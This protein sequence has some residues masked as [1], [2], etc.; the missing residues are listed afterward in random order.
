MVGLIGSGV[1]FGG[2]ATL[3]FYRV[4][5]SSRPTER[6]FWSYERLGKPLIH[7]TPRGRRLAKGVSLFDS[8]EAARAQ[9]IKADLGEYTAVLALAWDDFEIEQGRHGHYTVYAD[10]ADLLARVVQVVRL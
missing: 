10:P 2:S 4:I 3:T 7:D 5:K 6:D 9:A 8:L 1:G